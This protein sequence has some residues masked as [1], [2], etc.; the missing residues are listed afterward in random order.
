MGVACGKCNDNSAENVDVL[1]TK[2]DKVEY[3]RKGKSPT[4]ALFWTEAGLFDYDKP[5]E[6]QYC[7]KH[8][9]GDNH[10][11]RPL[12]DS[13]WHK[14]YSEDR[15][16]LQ[17]ALI[18]SLCTPGL[19]QDDLLL[20]WVVFTAGAMGAGKGYVMEWM[21][22]QGC[23]PLNQFVIVDPDE[24]RQK[25]PEWKGYVDKDPMTA[26][27][28]TQKEAGCMAEILGYKA[29]G[30]RANVI[31]DGSLRD[32][33]WYKLYFAKLR[34]AFPG[35]R[36]MIL[37]IQAE[38]QEVLD[39]AE[40][41]GRETGRM[42]PMEL[43][44]GSMTAVPKSVRELAPFVDVAI[45]VK[46]KNGVDPAMEP[47]LTAKNPAKGTVVNPQYIANLWN[48]IDCDGDGELSAEEVLSG[49]ATG[50]LTKEIIDTIDTDHDG[51]I[52]KSELAAA[53]DKAKQNAMMELAGHN[54]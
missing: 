28:K 51:K 44:E 54:S 16:E 38:R 12:L 53:R 48:P 50:L 6:D 25:L 23:L 18:A 21:Q 32:V 4:E 34:H 2:E 10:A 14:K 46:N 52:S 37:H 40:K 36:L 13:T 1:F 11:I 7:V 27:V 35:I 47:E 33:E 49:L 30:M 3:A 41:R 29:L 43:L 39:R 31:F 26:A 20:P 42:V 17:D 9:T 15:V 22:K 19:N 8:Y 24:I 45:K 5:T